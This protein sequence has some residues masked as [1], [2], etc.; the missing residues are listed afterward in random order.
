[1]K[2]I[3]LA[4]DTRDAFVHDVKRTP[5]E[6]PPGQRYRYTNAG[7]SLLGAMVE[8]VSGEKYQALTGLRFGAAGKPSLEVVFPGG[9]RV[10]LRAEG[11]GE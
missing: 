6:S 1:V 5:P 8:V 3:D 4:G 9:R 11:G 7:F 10:S 2:G